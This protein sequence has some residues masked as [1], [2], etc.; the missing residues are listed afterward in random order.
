MK[1]NNN[2]FIYFDKQDIL[3][4]FFPKINVEPSGGVRKIIISWNG[5]EVTLLANN[6]HTLSVY[7]AS[8][9]NIINVTQLSFLNN[10]IFKA[11]YFQ[12]SE[13][14]ANTRMFF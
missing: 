13:Q 10:L 5:K 9:N 3:I 8:P 12:P 4:G 11:S 1:E 14:T 6:V 2:G 7:K